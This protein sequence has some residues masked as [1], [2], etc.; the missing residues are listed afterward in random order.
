ML[1]TK[2]EPV[3]VVLKPRIRGR[4]QIN[5]FNQEPKILQLP[6]F[7]EA[8]RSSLPN[9]LE[10][11][12]SMSVLRWSSMKHILT[13]SRSNTLAKICLRGTSPTQRSSQKRIQIC[14]I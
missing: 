8:S 5:P 10:P 4:M 14:A 1:L 7:P 13:C 9:Q 3:N 6:K 2:N 12:P 11:T